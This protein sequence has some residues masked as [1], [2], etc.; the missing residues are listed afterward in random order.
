MLIERETDFKKDEID[1]LTINEKAKEIT[2]FEFKWANLPF[3]KQGKLLK[4]SKEKHN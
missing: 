4:N 2:F 1:I 3:R